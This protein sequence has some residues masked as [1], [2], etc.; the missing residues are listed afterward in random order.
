[1]ALYSLIGILV[2]SLLSSC[3][4]EKRE[5]T[6][7]SSTATIEVR[8]TI[9]VEQR[10]RLLFAGDAMCHTPQIRTAYRNGKLDF[11]NSFAATKHYFDRADI[12]VVNLETTISPNRQYSGYPSFS[13]PK[14][15]AEAL[16][17]LGVDVATLANNHCCDCGARGIRST[18]AT[19]D[20]LGIAHTGA[21]ADRENYVANEILRFEHDGI[22]LALVSYTFGTNGIKTPRGC[23]VNRIDT[24]RMVQ[25]LQRAKEGADCVIACVHWGEEYVQQPSY[26]Q[27]RLAK[28]LQR[29]GVDVVVGTHPHVVQP[30]EASDSLVTI[31]SL[32]NF[33][34]NQRCAHT[35]GGIIVEVEI[36]KRANERCRYSVDITPVWVKRP[37][38]ILVTPETE[39]VDKMTAYQ[40]M[41][42]NSFIRNTERLLTQD[43]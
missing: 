33:V 32:G 19:L 11:R 41:Q 42:Y 1:M 35:G 31:Y 15:Y 43:L 28:F 39:K 37:G 4:V 29:N 40:R 21:F 2:L 23:F 24:I 10:V 3:V 34:S 22:K 38:H 12:A 14:E 13:S 27:R 16:G 25:T 9:P 8:D 6:E 5:A 26:E 18:V 20:R 17:W 7:L 30:V 36:A